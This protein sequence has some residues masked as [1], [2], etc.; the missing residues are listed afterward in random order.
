MILRFWSTRFHIDVTII[1]F[2]FLVYTDSRVSFFWVFKFHR[3]TVTVFFN[4]H[5]SVNH[6]IIIRFWFY[7]DFFT[8]LE[9]IMM[10]SNMLL[11]RFYI[12][13]SFSYFYNIC[14]VLSLVMMIFSVWVLV[15]IFKR[16]GDGLQLLK[17]EEVLTLSLPHWYI[18]FLLFRFCDLVRFFPSIAFLTFNWLPHHFAHNSPLL[19]LLQAIAYVFEIEVSATIWVLKWKLFRCIGNQCSFMT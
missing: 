15:L 17:Y 1:S 6:H 11:L 4:D 19:Y 3:I 9:E 12:S 13:F 14:C 8:I 10:L 5:G 18:I 2:L 16:G 7:F